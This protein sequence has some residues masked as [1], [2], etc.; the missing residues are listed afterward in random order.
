VCLGTLVPAGTSDAGPE[1]V[2][3]MRLS[4][5]WVKLV[6]CAGDVLICVLSLMLSGWCGVGG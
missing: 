2:A 3:G 1:V 4:W 5:F 6:T